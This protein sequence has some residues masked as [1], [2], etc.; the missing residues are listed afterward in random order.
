MAS[1]PVVEQLEVLDRPGARAAARVAHAAS[2]TS[3]TFSVE[4]DGS[5]GRAAR[6]PSDYQDGHRLRSVHGLRSDTSSTLLLAS[7]ATSPP[8]GRE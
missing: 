1:L 8:V 4:A 6:H 3:S 2:W 5:S 7:R